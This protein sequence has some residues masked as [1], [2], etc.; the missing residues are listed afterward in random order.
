MDIE[1]RA[2]N[3]IGDEAYVLGTWLNSYANNA[4]VRSI[5][6]PIYYIQQRLRIMRILNHIETYI[7]VCCDKE[8]PEVIY[9][10]AVCQ[11]P[12][13]IHYIYTKGSYKNT[14]VARSLL[15]HFDKNEPVYYTHGP[16]EG[17]Q[18]AYLR[19][20]LHNFIYNPY[21]LETKE[22]K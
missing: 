7:L 18:A 19:D 14:S 22:C 9:G 4:D 12:N 2:Y 1:V 5:P 16:G 17:W 15:E 6:K 8:T 13:I 11:A 20:K 3:S 10:Y 21:L